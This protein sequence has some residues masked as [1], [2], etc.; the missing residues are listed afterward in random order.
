M[1]SQASSAFGCSE[2]VRLG[3]GRDHATRIRIAGVDTAVV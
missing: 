3:A 1:A 2:V